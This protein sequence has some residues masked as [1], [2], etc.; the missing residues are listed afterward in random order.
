M[1]HARRLYF[2]SLCKLH[3]F[4]LARQVTQKLKY[5]CRGK[6]KSERK[7]KCG[8][9]NYI[10]LALSSMCSQDIIRW[11]LQGIKK[12]GRSLKNA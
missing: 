12:A 11:N 1:W 10:C 9:K 8:D 6:G 2:L 3:T 5:E 7:L 4:K